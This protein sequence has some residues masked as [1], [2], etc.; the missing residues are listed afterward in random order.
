M[1]GTRA[2]QVEHCLKSALRKLVYHSSSFVGCSTGRLLEG[3]RDNDY[4]TTIVK[5]RSGNE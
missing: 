1:S 4:R 2:E 3:L 5:D